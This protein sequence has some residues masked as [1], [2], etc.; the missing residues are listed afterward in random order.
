MSKRKRRGWKPKLKPSL[1]VRRDARKNVAILTPAMDLC[2]TEWACSIANMCMK[3]MMDG[4]PVGMAVLTYGSSILPF[5]RQHLASFAVNQGFTHTLWIDSDM[6]FPADTLLRFLS[7]DEPIIGINAMTRR[8]PFRT[9]AKTGPDDNL[10]TTRD[11]TGLEKVE[12]M[13]FGMVWIQAEVYSR[14][15]KPWFDTEWVPDKEVHRG[16]DYYFFEKARRA[17][18]ELYV[19]HDLSKEVGHIGSF[20]FYPYMVPGGGA[21]K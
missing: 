6:R 4:P 7:R 20:T 15:E 2:H 11:S 10:P 18:Y 13:G 17:G 9:T 3:T 5:S 16:E 14:I 19:D 21:S 8:E 1:E 12:L